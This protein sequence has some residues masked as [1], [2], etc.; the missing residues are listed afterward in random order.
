MPTGGCWL[1][2]A[3]AAAAKSLLLLVFCVLVVCVCAR[4]P[5]GHAGVLADLDGAGAELRLVH[6]LHRPLRLG[7]RGEAHLG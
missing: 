6:G 3:A 2:A 4:A 5:L 7:R 1:L